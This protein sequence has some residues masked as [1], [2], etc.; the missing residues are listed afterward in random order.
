MAQKG[1]LYRG[2]EDDRVQTAQLGTVTMDIPQ[3][4]TILQPQF[5]GGNVILQS[6]SSLAT[7]DRK[8]V[9]AQAGW[10][11]MTTKTLYDVLPYSESGIY[12]VSAYTSDAQVKKTI[13]PGRSKSRSTASRSIPPIIRLSR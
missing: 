12:T 1:L 9:K 7:R 5:E 11:L 4:S 6:R 3:S 2:A 10:G 13:V 8:I